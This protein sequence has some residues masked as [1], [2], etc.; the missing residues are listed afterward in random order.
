MNATNNKPLYRTL[1]EERTQGKWETGERDNPEDTNIPYWI[2]VMYSGACQP[3]FD[4]ASFK[5][6]TQPQLD[7]MKADAEYTA[8]AVNNLHYLAEALQNFID[9]DKESGWGY[10][11]EHIIQATEALK[12]IS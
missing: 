4:T 3:V 2:S 10:K 9:D 1:N 6:N 12:R 7:R 11:A 5:P 8:L